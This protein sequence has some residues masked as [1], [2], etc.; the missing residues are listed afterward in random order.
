MTIP[1]FLCLTILLLPLPLLA[2]PATQPG[3]SPATS[4]ATQPILPN[5]SDR[6]Q[7]HLAQH[8]RLLLNPDDEKALAKRII[9]EPKLGRLWQRLLDHADALLTQPALER[10]LTGRRLLGVSREAL[11]RIATFSLAYRVLS[12]R[13]YLQAGRDCMLAVASF[14]DWNP[15][16]FLDVAEAT[17]AM[18]IGY[19]WLY[20][21]LSPTDRQTIREAIVE[22]GLRASFTPKPQWW[23]NAPINWNQ[24]CNGGLTMGALAVAEDE[25]ELAGQVVSRALTGVP[26]EMHSYAPDGAYPEGM[27]YWAYGTTYNAF[28]IAGLQTAVG[29]DFDLPKQPGFLKTSLYRLH[30]VGPS[31]LNF[32]YCDG[33]ERDALEPSATAFYLANL[34]NDP[35]LL[36][37][38]LASLDRLL[39]SPKATAG[40][41]RS[42][43]LLLLWIA[44]T[45]APPTPPTTHYVA[46]GETPVAAHR[47]SWDANA[48]FA[49]I[50]GGSPS[51]NHAHMDVGS[52]CLDALG[53][54]WIGDLGAQDYES[55]ESKN[56]DLWNSRQG[57]QR[58]QVFRLGPLS[59]NILTVDGQ[60][61][62]VKGSAEITQ[63][64]ESFTTVDLAPVYVGQLTAAMRGILLR[65]DGTVLLQD[66]IRNAT[67]PATVRWAVLTAA[68]VKVQGST[69]VLKKANKA[70]LVRVV[71]PA[72]AKLKIVSTDPPHDY[73]A[74][75]PGTR[76]LTFEA[77]LQPNE[78]KTLAVDFIPT[79]AL[80]SAPPATQP[81]IPLAAWK[82]SPTTDPSR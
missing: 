54:R 79:N 2:G 15:S 72:N 68:D 6:L 7:N 13:R 33:H 36:W 28:L 41:D 18:A 69:A 67:K 10:H 52:F 34:N 17:T 80:S 49:A 47:S 50:K 30:L 20:A 78:S 53:V 26:F 59:H 62:I 3:I 21:D 32:S 42:D 75:N 51:S 65:P 5:V 74:K 29:D 81:I 44:S 82:P 64:T 25:P 38:E 58:W 35:S 71:S 57:S 66:E 56:I 31:G 9:K 70:L 46:A 27:G 14:D 16:H 23:I 22:K 73:D 63:S 8:P 37:N 48:T 24:V 76:L 40:S 77:T 45:I 12:D 39:Q 55:L 19:D 4:P 1:R 43:W 61:Q 60:E 11:D